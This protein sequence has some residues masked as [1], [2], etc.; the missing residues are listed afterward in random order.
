MK[1]L[2]KTIDKIWGSGTNVPGR[3][4]AEYCRKYSNRSLDKITGIFY[5]N[6]HSIADMNKT[7]CSLVYFVSFKPLGLLHKLPSLPQTKLELSGF[8][9]PPQQNYSHDSD[10]Y[11]LLSACCDPQRGGS[12][13]GWQFEEI[14]QTRRAQGRAGQGKEGKGKGKGKGRAG[15]RCHSV[16]S[17]YFWIGL[18]N[19]LPLLPAT[20]DC[21]SMM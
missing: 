17:T 5:I 1:Q 6:N 10:P 21:S 12:W 2:D 3:L 16:T 13:E 7:K 8:S 19:H 20:S 4:K 18:G 11:L 9:A 14:R 15:Q